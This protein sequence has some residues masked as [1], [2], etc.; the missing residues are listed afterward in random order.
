MT[1]IS[2]MVPEIWSAMDR[3]FCHF[4][5]FFTLLPPKQPKKSKF[6]KNEK[7][8][9]RYHHS[10]QVYQKM[11]KTSGDIIILHKCTKNYDHMLYCS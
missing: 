9:R 10:T 2:C 5:P 1:I 7:N 11:K 4:E 6:Q 3:I 8:A